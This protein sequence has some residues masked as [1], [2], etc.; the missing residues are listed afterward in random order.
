MEHS[1]Q[2]RQVGRTD[3][4]VP[5]L[6]LGTAPVGGMPSAEEDLAVA[7]VRHAL[8]RGMNLIDTAP[9]YGSGLSERR[10]GA[11]LQGVP[12]NS[13]VLSTKVARRSQ[14][15]GEPRWNRDDILR[16]VEESL[17]RLQLERIDVLLIHDPDT[18]YRGALDIAF[19]TV[20]ELRRQGLVSAIGS[21]MN[22]WQ[23]L[24]DF[25]RNADFDCFLLAGRYTLLEQEPAAEF[26]PYCHAHDI[27]VF[28][29]GVYNSGILATGPQPGATY[30]YREAPEPIMDRARRLEA[31]CR[32][33]DVPLQV[34]ALQFP[35]AHPGVTAIV[36]GARS[37]AEVDAGA[38]ALKVAIP[39]ALW[40][41]LRAA[42]LLHPDVPTPS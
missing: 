19:P 40:D 1:H 28:L 23:M 31:I 7:T 10:V 12:R 13:F 38:E 16:S 27:S 21:G 11:A 5:V 22:Q 34:A 15:Q 29:G 18:D 6:G 30:N 14:P 41:D 32:R 17:Q 37:P 42:E 39:P 3:L 8:D 36:M 35:L 26:L 24:F 20:A 4:R 25:A 9:L 2:M 33:Y